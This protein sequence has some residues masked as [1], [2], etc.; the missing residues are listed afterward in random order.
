MDPLKEKYNS[1]LAREKKAE[2][3]FNKTN[4]NEADKWLPQFQKIIIQLSR[5]IYQIEKQ[6]GR[7]LTKQEVSEGFKEGLNN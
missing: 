6:E 7:K 4:P 5:L 3:F 1:T 2:E